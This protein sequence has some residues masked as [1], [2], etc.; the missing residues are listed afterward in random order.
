M[1]APT[2]PILRGAVFAAGAGAPVLLLH[3]SAS[4]AVMWAPAIDAL[5]ADFRVLAPDLIG[6]GRTD[7]WLDG[8]DFTAGDELCLIEPLLPRGAAVHVVGHSYG[9]L[10]AMHLALAGRVALRSL[11]LIEPVAF[12]LLPHAGAQEAWAEINKL[13]DDYAARIAAG[14]AEA[15]L[16]GFIDYWAGS[17]AWDAMDETLRAQIRR[18]ARKVLLDFQVAFTD[19]GLAGLRALTCPVR[20]LAGGRSRSPT[21]RIAAF[22]AE[23]MP[24]AK[25][26]V[27]ADANHLLPV[28]HPDMLAAWLRQRLAD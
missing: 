26:E 5:K 21:R 6:Y 9:G 3:G 24:T 7:P 28:T 14:D 13:A 12:F 22:L 8:A 15:A 1:T 11:T 18:S 20:L 23:V 16:R 2:R 17:G 4:A 19:P 25:L 10:V 27:V